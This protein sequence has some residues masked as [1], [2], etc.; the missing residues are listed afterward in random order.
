M[1]IINLKELEVD[2]VLDTLYKALSKNEISDLDIYR[3]GFSDADGYR[4]G[5]SG[6]TFGVS[7]F[8]LFTN[9][10]EATEIL[11]DCG[12][13][14]SQIDNIANQRL[15]LSEIKNLSS[16]LKTPK[17]KA[18]ID[19]ADKRQMKEL[20]DTMQLYLLNKGITEIYLSGFIAACDYLNQ[21]GATA[22]GALVT[23]IKNNYQ[24]GKLV[25][26]LDIKNFKKTILWGKKRPDDV[27]RRFNNI[28]KV[29][30]GL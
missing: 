20:L 2:F 28:E 12:F 30:N 15:S 16:L 5:T 18:V 26:N 10:K 22:N 19:N 7:Q 21:I 27:E 14:K 11:L 9:R 23:F 1:S 29:C 24:D 13:S 3:Y 8:D 4:K 25:S 6:I 17:A